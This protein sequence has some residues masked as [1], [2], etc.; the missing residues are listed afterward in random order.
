VINDEVNDKS[1]M[2]YRQIV[3]LFAARLSILTYFTML[4]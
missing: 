3:V 4:L 1:I 2:Q